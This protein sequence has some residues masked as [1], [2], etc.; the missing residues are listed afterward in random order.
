MN[1]EALEVFCALGDDWKVTPKGQYKSIDKLALGAVMEMMEVA[2]RKEMLTN[3]II[4]QNAA[5]EILSNG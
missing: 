3:I 1:Q 5:L 2:N 4:M